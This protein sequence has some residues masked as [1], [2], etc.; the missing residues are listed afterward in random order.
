MPRKEIYRNWI[1]KGLCG[2]CGKRKPTK[3]KKICSICLKK[4]RIRSKKRYWDKKENPIN[5]FYW[6]KK[7]KLNF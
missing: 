1:N 2:K 6:V 5:Q 7:E 3:D 4:E